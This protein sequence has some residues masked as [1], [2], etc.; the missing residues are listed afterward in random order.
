MLAHVIELVDQ[1]DIRIRLATRV[2][3]APKSRHDRVIVVAE[4][5]P[6]QDRGPVDRHGFDHDHRGTAEHA[7]P[8]VADVPLTGKAIL[9]HVG[10]V[11]PEGDPAR[12]RL[13]AEAERLEDVRE[14]IRHVQTSRVGSDGGVRAAPGVAPAAAPAAVASLAATA[15]DASRRRRI[16]SIAM[17]PPIEVVARIITW[18]SKYF[19]SII[20]RSR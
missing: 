8:V 18:T 15:S 7:F 17:T 12:E 2:G 14:A 20:P 10:G 16:A 9:G 1:D 11:R 13:V 4:V 5:A 3:E 19:Y 6:R